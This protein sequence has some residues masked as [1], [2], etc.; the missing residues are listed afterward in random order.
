M[1]NK[2]Q[3]KKKKLG[4]ISKNDLEQL[5]LRNPVGTFMLRFSERN[6]GSLSIG[7]NSGDI[8]N[9]IRHCLLSEENAGFH[10]LFFIFYFIFYFIF[11]FIFFL[12]IILKTKKKGKNLSKIADF[13]GEDST[14]SHFCRLIPK[15]HTQDPQ[16]STPSFELV[17]KHTALEN[18]YSKTSKSTPSIEG[19]DTKIVRPQ[20]LNTNFNFGMMNQINFQDVE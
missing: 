18:F 8:Q 11:G 19:Y 2:K 7:Y 12:F 13:I 10:F 4:F 3:F 15:I 5:L 17:Q 16:S 6:S 9:P 14:L 1:L 20:T